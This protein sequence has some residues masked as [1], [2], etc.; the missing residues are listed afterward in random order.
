MQTLQVVKLNL[1]S[2]NVWFPCIGI[3]LKND[4]IITN[5]PLLGINLQ[6]STSLYI[7]YYQLSSQ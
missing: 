4:I 6:Q 7:F 5:Q 2:C 1:P 3:Y